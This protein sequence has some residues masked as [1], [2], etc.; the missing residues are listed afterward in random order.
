MERT[1]LNLP[2]LAYGR[3]RGT[4]IEMYKLT[5][6]FYDS[7]A[8]DRL[9]KPNA[10]ISRGNQK[11]VMSMKARI[12]SRRNCFT[13]LAAKDEQSARKGY[14]QLQSIHRQK[15]TRQALG[16]PLYNHLRCGMARWSCSQRQRL[17]T[18]KPDLNPCLLLIGKVLWC[19]R[20][21]A[22]TFSLQT[23]YVLSTV[24]YISPVIFVHIRVVFLR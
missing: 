9:F 19:C 15:E 8:S 14:V 21:L 24:I 18:R 17:S 2:T 20:F 10:R 23:V 6:Q 11:K 3:K 4:M 16:W 1:G 5:N 13:V 22:E 7:S 12:E